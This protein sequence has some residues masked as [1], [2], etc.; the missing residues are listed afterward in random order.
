MHSL[1]A[2]NLSFSEGIYDLNHRNIEHLTLSSA[3]MLTQVGLV[4]TQNGIS[5]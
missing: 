3:V 5:T 4:T 1:S 2:F